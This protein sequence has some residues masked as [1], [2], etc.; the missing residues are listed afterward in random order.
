M[1]DI[2]PSYQNLQWKLGIESPSLKYAS[3]TASNNILFAVRIPYPLLKIWYDL[4]LCSKL[5]PDTNSTSTGTHNIYHYVDLLECSIPGHSFGITQDENVQS[6]IND[7]LR[8]LAS[9]VNAKLRGLKGRKRKELQ[10]RTKLFHILNGQTV[11]VE[12]LRKENKLIYDQLD[13]WKEAYENL[14]SETRKLH[15]EMQQALKEKDR[16]ISELSSENEELQKYIEKLQ[17]KST[18]NEKTFQKCKKRTLAT[19]M[20]RAQVAL[21][22]AESFGLKFESMTVSETKTGIIHDLSAE[23]KKIDAHGFDNLPQEEKSKVEK[24][25]SY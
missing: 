5:P 21:W 23:K 25:Y 7:S 13:E 10:S 9:S 22:F 16:K 3:K 24:Y 18:I 14:E 15:Q 6:K 11:S 19:F 8:G 17:K 20:S 2:G 4:D 1:S 12:D